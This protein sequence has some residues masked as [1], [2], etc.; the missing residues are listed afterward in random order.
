MLKRLFVIFTTV[1]ICIAI[2]VPNKS[3]IF[4]GYAPKFEL[5]LQSASSNAVMVVANADDYSNFINVKGESFKTVKEN[6]NLHNFFSDMNAKLLFTES[7]AE[8]TS[9]YAF[10]KSIRYRDEV[11]GEV[12]NLHVFISNATNQVKVGSPLIYGSF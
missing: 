4:Y 6:F 2:L 9:Y 10:S 5:Y 3:P 8:G 11:R 7:V 12:V 1:F